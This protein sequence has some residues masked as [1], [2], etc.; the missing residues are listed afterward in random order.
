MH[1]HVC[2]KSPNFLFLGGIE[3]HHALGKLV[4]NKII[5]RIIDYYYTILNRST[6]IWKLLDWLNQTIFRFITLAS[7]IIMRALTG[8]IFVKLKLKSMEFSLLFSA[9]H[10]S[11]LGW[12]TWSKKYFDNTN[13][14][15]KQNRKNSELLNLKVQCV[16]CCH[17]VSSDGILRC[18]ALGL[19]IWIK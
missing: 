19:E 14:Y 5:Y 15:K 8:C 13:S 11:P 12:K 17:R 4:D 6:E 1:K 3:N 16:D 7:F 18:I 2:Q 10:H 9:K